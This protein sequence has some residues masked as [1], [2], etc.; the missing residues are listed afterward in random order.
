MIRNPKS[1]EVWSACS[2][3][4]HYVITQLEMRPPS[5][6]SGKSAALALAEAEGIP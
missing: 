2:P 6:F 4:V 1:F 3:N 5:I